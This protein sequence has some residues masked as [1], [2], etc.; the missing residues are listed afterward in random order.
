[1]HPRP[2]SNLEKIDRLVQALGSS[3]LE[4]SN[5][6]ESE[7]AQ[8][9]ELMSLTSSLQSTFLN[10]GIFDSLTLAKNKL[11]PSDGACN[12]RKDDV[13]EEDAML[14]EQDEEEEE[15]E[16]DASW[17]EFDASWKNVVKDKNPV[18]SPRRSGNRRGHQGAPAETIN[19]IVVSTK[20]ND[21]VLAPKRS[22]PPAV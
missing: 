20:T 10:F 19:T 15:D 6:D 3:D 5:S 22:S 1:M 18:P 16:F 2:S 12:H 7:D 13:D 17:R 21:G 4:P 14:L 11:R 8:G 9:E